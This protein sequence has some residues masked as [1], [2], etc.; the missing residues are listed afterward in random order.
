M[1]F[2]YQKNLFPELEYVFNHALTHEVAYSSILGKLRRNLHEKIGVVIEQIYGA[3]AEE[4]FEMLAHHFSRSDNFEKAYHYSKLS[5]QK[6]TRDNSAWE[7]Y[8]FYREAIRALKHLPDVEENRKMKLEVFHLVLIPIILLGLPE[9]SL[10]I[11]Q[12]GADVSK[13]L[14]DLKSLSRFYTN[15]GLYFSS[16]GN[17]KEGITYSGKAFDEAV[18]VDDI[19]SMARSGPDLCLAYMTLGDFAKVIEVAM[20]VSGRLEERGMESETFGGPTNVYSALVSMWG[21]SMGMMGDF[22]EAMALCEKGIQESAKTGRPTTKG[23]CESYFGMLLLVKGEWDMA[24]L[25]L[26]KSIAYLEEAEFIQPLALAWTRLGH[27]LT[28][29]ED[30][31]TA[32][33]HLEKGL[34]IHRKSGTEWFLSIHLFF[35]SIWHYYSE[36]FDQAQSL[37][38]ETYAL[39]KKNH[40]KYMKGVSQIWLG[41][42]LGKGDWREDKGAEELIRGGVK[43]LES[44]GTRPDLS[45]GHLFLG[46]LYG[47]LGRKE[48][49]LKCLNKA[50]MMFREMDMKYW[51]DV[52]S[53]IQNKLR[54]GTV[55]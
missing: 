4:V 19:E 22:D 15:M 36:A 52:T 17:L 21:N 47:T 54:Q 55:M 13:V 49:A 9:D 48:A 26:R 12:E 30:Y 42:I 3:G 6:A 18:K 41:R 29:L 24:A 46:E 39:A 50:W 31:K 27:A 35:L 40:E 7:A 32:K 16:R 20:A 34:E 38:E 43:I 1:E 28:H 37:M 8:G 10:I 5:G 53:E 51:Q 23:V 44:L 14:G 2:I 45:A 33:K 25:H 11:L